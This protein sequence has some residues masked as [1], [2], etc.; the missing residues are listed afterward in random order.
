MPNTIS[1]EVVDVTAG[2][3]VEYD[4]IA[5]ERRGPLPGVRDLEFESLAAE[6]RSTILGIGEIFKPAPGGP[7]SSEIKFGMKVS[8]GGKVIVASLSGEVTLEVKLAWKRES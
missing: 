3:F 7:E 4:H 1:I 5:N 2:P 8:A 6:M